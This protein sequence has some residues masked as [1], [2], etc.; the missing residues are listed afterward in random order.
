MNYLYIP[1]LSSSILEHCRVVF[2]RVDHTIE[3]ITALPQNSLLPH[4]GKD[5][6]CNTGAQGQLVKGQRLVMMIAR[7]DC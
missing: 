7:T 6:F 5:R 4:I 2:M 3:V 1:Q